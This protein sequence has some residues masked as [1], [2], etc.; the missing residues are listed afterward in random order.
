MS[1]LTKRVIEAT[2]PGSKE[3]SVWDGALP[4]F[5]LRVM[6][7]GRKSYV[8]QY[9]AGRRSRRITLGPTS[10]ITPDQARTRAI[11]IL[12]EVR[13]GKDPAADRDVGRTAM[14][15]IELAQRFDDQHIAIRIKESTARE[16]RRNLRRF[17]LP[18]IGRMK[19]T[20]VTRADIA[21]FHHDLRHIPYQANRCL[22]IISKM[23]NLAEVWGLRADGS[24]PRRHLQKYPEKKR[25]RYLSPAE[26]KRIGE[27]LREVE[28][29]GRELASAVLAI[30]LL[31][32]TG[33]RLSEITKLKWEYVDLEGSALHLPDSK[34]GAKTVH[35]GRPAVELLEGAPVI[36]GN[37]WVITGKIEGGRLTDLQPFWQRVRARA[38]LH[39]VRIHDLRHTFASTAV[40]AG[41]SLPMIGALLGHT[42]VQTTA[43]YAHLASAPVKGAAEVISDLLERVMSI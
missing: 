17:I 15:V 32:Y 27:V 30:R 41:Q 31:I 29:E 28:A 20:E 37:P 5:G 39:D 21:K 24:N 3:V 7:S 38:G 36:V 8:V 23:F 43:R 35:V 42:Q 26:L 10:I 22:E 12:S 25:E 14:L 2:E 11:A 13:A 34:T 16:Y 6:P 19:V 40:G 1:K 9:R 18:A 33:C 4:G